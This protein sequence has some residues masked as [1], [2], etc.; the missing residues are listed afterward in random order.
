MACIDHLICMTSRAHAVS[1]VR[2]LSHSQNSV[3]QSLS[4]G[5]T[6]RASDAWPACDIDTLPPHLRPHQDETL[7]LI[8]RQKI[9]LLQARK[10]YRANVDSHI[11][12]HYASNVFSAQKQLINPQRYSPRVLDLGAAN[13]L[14]SILFSRAHSPSTLHLVELQKLLVARAR[15][16]LHL[17]D[18]D[19]IVSNHDLR[20]GILPE[21][22]KASFDV[23]LVNPPFYQANSRKPAKNIERRLAQMES[24]ASLADFLRAASIACD[25]NSWS[26][27]IALIHDV[28]EIPRLLDTV[29]KLNIGIFNVQYMRHSPNEAPTRILFCLRPHLS[30]CKI[31]QIKHGLTDIT[32]PTMKSIV[33]HPDANDP[34]T[35]S[36]EL[37]HFLTSLQS[38]TLR[39]GRL[40]S[41]SIKEG[42]R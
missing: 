2:Y 37:E 42:H 18:L 3:S 19:G 31:R 28:S 9:Y 30:L 24:S 22:L 34:A 15:R 13:G 20:G 29:Q 26:S 35:F 38:P 10:G 4:M 39:I 27:F 40:R 11:L 32:A 7:D 16:N 23:I 21:T 41:Q 1:R 36:D 8:F 33:L 25:P 5:F 12:A 17:N 14:V 6:R